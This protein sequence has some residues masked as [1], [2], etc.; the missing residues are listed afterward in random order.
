M[1]KRRRRPEA[2]IREIQYTIWVNHE[3]NKKFQELLTLAGN[4]RPKDYL[5]QMITQG[6]VQASPNK[7]NKVDVEKFYELLVEYKTNF[8]RLSNLIRTN[9]MALA[10]EIK[11]LVKSIQKVMDRI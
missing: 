2:L 4:M 5:R 8:N 9:D 1:Q 10:I 6:F 7:S 3:E 11:N